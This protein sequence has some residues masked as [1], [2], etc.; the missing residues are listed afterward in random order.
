MSE[1]TVI[2]LVHN[3]R[4]KLPRC[5]KSVAWADDLFCI[6]DPNTSDG[7]GEI[8]KKFTDHVVPHE[9]VNYASQMTWAL[10]QIKTE[11]TFVL[12]ADEW[13]SPEL[14]ARLQ[15]I[16]KAPAG[17]DGVEVR[18]RSYFFGKLIHHSGWQRDYKLRLFRTA[19]V[20]YPARRVHS[21]PIVDGRVGQLN[22]PLYHDTYSTFEQYF[23]TFGR[24]TSWGAADLYDAG[25]RA[26]LGDLALRPL[27]RFVKT[28][29]VQQGFRDGR[30]GAVLCGLSACYVFT[31][32]AK[33][34]HLELLE[35]TGGAPG[36]P[37]GP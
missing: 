37:E 19:K 9:Y 36:P 26:R 29:F 2:T 21:R 15:S 1:V 23:A 7:S 28:Y 35:K 3:V 30:H 16:I 18:R 14:A 25:R 27:L 24:F 5:L 10:P 4:D 33:L 13:V 32:Y 12:D 31:K 6:L 22:E 34:W 20:H 11:W 17:L 8:A